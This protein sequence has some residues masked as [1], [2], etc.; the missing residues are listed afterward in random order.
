MR[1]SWALVALL[2]VA[3]CRDSAVHAR[4]EF[5]EATPSTLDFGTVELGSSASLPVELAGVGSGRLE[6]PAPFSADDVAFTVPASRVIT[7][8]PSTPDVFAADVALPGGGV[9]HLQGAGV[10]RCVADEACVTSTWS[11]AESRCVR[12]DAPEGTA[13]ATPCVSAG[14]C[15]AGQCVGAATDC[16][17]ANACTVDAC[18]SARG[19]EHLPAQC[20]AP[21]DP[22]LA[23]TCDP[24]TGCATTRVADGTR[25]DEGECADAHVCIEGQ[26]V[27]RAAP[28]GASCGT[29]T[30]CRAAGSCNG[31]QCVRPAAHKLDLAWERTAAPYSISFWGLSDGN[32][33]WVENDRHLVSVRP[34]GSVRFDVELGF[35]VRSTGG[36]GDTALL[37]SG[38]IVVSSFEGA[39]VEARRVTDG[40]LAWRLELPRR[41][42]D[43]ETFHVTDLAARSDALYVVGFHGPSPGARLTYETA[44]L[45]LEL[46]TGALLWQRWVAMPLG[47][48]WCIPSVLPTVALDSHDQPVMG[49]EAQPSGSGQLV[50]LTGY[51]PGGA[52]RWSVDAGVR[53]L[54]TAGDRVFFAD[55]FS[56]GWVEED[57]GLDVLPSPIPSAMTEPSAVQTSAGVVLV[58]HE[59]IQRVLARTEANGWRFDSVFNARLS[60][61]PSASPA[62]A[63]AQGKVSFA[64]YADSSVGVGGVQPVLVELDPAT[65]AT[66]S[67]E[68]DISP[69]TMLNTLERGVELPGLFVIS[70][71]SKTHVWAYRR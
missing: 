20:A 44:L 23:A 9:L 8:A 70:D 1:N 49:G 38:L 45:R 22:C 7:F 25:C 42:A 40:S 50:R 56:M 60:V 55:P 17:D 10:E 58:G 63:T 16:E 71:W 39:F 68:F 62:I 5:V 18:D 13:C 11:A 64:S 6:L 52:V 3:G 65:A 32:L 41:A 30:S 46:S 43:G 14:S 12:A 66:T 47:A 24:L 29:P 67:C 61:S 34:D 27:V 37:A 48:C 19:C 57:G 59:Q 53:L 54:G 26:C 69:S 51:T 31:G 15:H 4:E 33:Y 35:T 21:S 36:P 2:F 28:D